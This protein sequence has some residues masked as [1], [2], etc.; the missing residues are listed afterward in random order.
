MKEDVLLTGGLEPTNEA[1]ALSKIIGM[2]L[3]QYYCTQFQRSFI[4]VV[5]PNIYGINDN[6]TDKR[7]SVMTGLIKRIHEAKINNLPEVIVWGTGNVYRE[8]I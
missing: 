7:S 5:P 2:K 1:Y 6:F 4:S 8:F 3:C